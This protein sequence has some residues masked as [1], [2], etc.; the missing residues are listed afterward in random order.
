MWCGAWVPQYSVIRQ[1]SA[2]TKIDFPS[3]QYQFNHTCPTEG[4]A[5]APR[6]LFLDA[7]DLAKRLARVRTLI[8]AVLDDQ[9]SGRRPAQV[10]D[11]LVKWLHHLP[12]LMVTAA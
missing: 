12:A 6:Q 5:D 4:E 8:V 2:T 10:I 1:N 11:G 3:H 7:F 9:R